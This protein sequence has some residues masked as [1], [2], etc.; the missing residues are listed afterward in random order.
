MRF[1]DADTMLNHLL[2]RIGFLPAWDNVVDE[3]DRPRVFAEVK[4]RLN[5][6]ARQQ[7]ELR[8][9][10]PMVYLESRRNSR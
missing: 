1:L 7:G 3:A 2:V 6:V 9:T 4:A 5:E 8:L 10:V